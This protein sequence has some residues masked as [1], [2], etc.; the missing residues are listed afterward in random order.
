LKPSKN[1]NTMLD[2]GKEKDM[3]LDIAFTPESVHSSN[4]ENSARNIK[5]V[6]NGA[7]MYETFQSEVQ[8]DF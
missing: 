6:E 4:E 5:K 8:Y 1:K 7:Q 3:Q 2:L